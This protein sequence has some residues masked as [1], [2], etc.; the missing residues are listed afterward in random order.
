MEF[1]LFFSIRGLFLTLAE[2]SQVEVVCQKR[3]KFVGFIF[4]LYFTGG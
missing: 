1:Q 2:H 3:K 4:F